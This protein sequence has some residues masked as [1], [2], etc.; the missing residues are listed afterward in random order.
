MVIIAVR[1]PVIQRRGLVRSVACY[2]PATPA[3]KSAFKVTFKDVSRHLTRAQLE[4][5]PQSMLTKLMSQVGQ[6]CSG[7]EAAQ[8]LAVPC[9][10]AGHSSAGWL[11]GNEDVFHVSASQSPIFPGK[12]LVYVPL[13]QDHRVTASSKLLLA[14]R[15]LLS[16]Q[17]R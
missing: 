5:A 4:K 2:A 1:A 17:N 10:G 12:Q 9:E 7:T 11:D 3:D 13:K 8:E 16:A 6:T 14:C 15:S